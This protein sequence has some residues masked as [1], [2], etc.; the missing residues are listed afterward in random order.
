M[1]EQ[2][3]RQSRTAGEEAVGGRAADAELARG[4]EFVAVIEIE[5]K[6]DV[7]VDDVVEVEGLRR[8]NGGAGGGG[9]R[10]SDDRKVF[11]AKDAAG[12]LE[13][14]RFEDAGKFTYVSGP[15][16]LEEALV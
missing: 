4:F 13:G 7:V 2:S 6:K 14:R 16:V 12:R 3:E 9:Q 10:G 5:D 15:I 11:G 1:T 8:G